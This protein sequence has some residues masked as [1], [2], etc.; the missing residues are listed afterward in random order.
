MEKSK[1]ICWNCKNC[2]NILECSWSSDFKPV[3]GWTATPTKINMGEY[4]V[5][6]SFCVHACPK[7]VRDDRFEI[8]AEE[9]AQMLNMNC[10]KFLYNIR[11]KYQIIEK[12]LEKQGYRLVV[13]Q[14]EKWGRPTY[15]LETIKR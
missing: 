14:D 4:G 1:T 13:F 11:K 7:F 8:G 9:L 6:D 10:N 12:K 2:G 15:V 3:E 5:T